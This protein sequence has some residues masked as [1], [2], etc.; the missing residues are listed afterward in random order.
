MTEPSRKARPEPRIVATSVAVGCRH[1]RAAVASARL[2]SQGLSV[3]V[4]MPRPPNRPKRRDLLHAALVVEDVL[5]VLDDRGDGLE[6]E[7]PIGPFDHVLQIEVLDREM[8][9]AVAERAAH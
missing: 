5:I 7:S 8:V 4:L 2:R 3:A 9:V 6:R 1:G